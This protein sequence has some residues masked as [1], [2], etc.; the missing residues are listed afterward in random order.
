[1]KNLP[2][3]IWIISERNGLL[4][5]PEHIP[6]DAPQAAHGFTSADQLM[7]F[8]SAQKGGRW[9]LDLLPDRESFAVAIAELHEKKISQLCVDPKPDGSDGTLLSLSAAYSMC[10]AA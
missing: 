6:C 9:K 10:G 4:H 5:P 1:M 2:L 8:L 3:P 7:A